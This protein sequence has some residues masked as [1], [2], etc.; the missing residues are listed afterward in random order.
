MRKWIQRRTAGKSVFGIRRLVFAKW[1]ECQQPN[2]ARCW[3]TASSFKD[4]FC[5]KNQEC[6]FWKSRIY[7]HVQYIFPMREVDAYSVRAPTCHL[8]TLCIL[9]NTRKP[10]IQWHNKCTTVHNSLPKTCR[11]KNFLCCA[12]SWYVAIDCIVLYCLTF[13]SGFALLCTRVLMQ[14]MCYVIINYWI[15][16]IKWHSDFRIQSQPCCVLWSFYLRQRKM[17]GYIF[18]SRLS[19]CGETNRCKL[20]ASNSSWIQHLGR[21]VDDSS[22]KIFK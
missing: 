14:R 11:A 6:A 22:K 4:M 3:K 18:L 8:E 2:F 16:Y 15:S 13:R 1:N 19:R 12:R 20:W 17:I 10:S 9:N 7:S 5:A 21:L